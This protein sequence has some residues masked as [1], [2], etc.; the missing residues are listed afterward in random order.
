M[1]SMS[2][3]F[4]NDTDLITV[5]RVFENGEED[6]KTMNLT[7]FVSALTD[8]IGKTCFTELGEI[9]FGYFRGSI[10]PCDTSSFKVAVIIPQD[11][12]I[13]SY[14]NEDHLVPFPELLFLFNVK[15]G[16]VNKSYA[17]SLVSSKNRKIVAHYPYGNVY[18]DGRI[19]WGL[20][21]LP[22]VENMKGIEHI[23][24][25]FF[26]SET[27]DHL[28][29]AGTNIIKREEFFN[30]R[31]LI[32]AAEGR[33]RFPAKWLKSYHLLLNEVTDGFFNS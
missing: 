5:Y 23:V 10:N 32:L 4:K 20:N 2:V 22:R 17:Y 12:R 9:P 3:Y 19:C 1:E 27:N 8:S 18:D 26:G 25:L 21:H 7:D 33:K 6:S 11:K 29:A 28:Y 24:D 31:G 14:Y 16:W 30:Q 15:S 13:L